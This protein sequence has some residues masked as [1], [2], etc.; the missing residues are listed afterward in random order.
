MMKEQLISRREGEDSLLEEA[1]EFLDAFYEN[2]GLAGSEQ[3]MDRWKK[4]SIFF[5]YCHREYTVRAPSDL[6]KNNPGSG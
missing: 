4:A 3:H 1:K 5:Q 6:N 2:E